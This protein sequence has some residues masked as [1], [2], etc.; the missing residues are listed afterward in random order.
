MYRNGK[1]S[2]IT[3][4]ISCTIANWNSKKSEIR[5]LF[6]CS[7]LNKNI[8]SIIDGLES[9]ELEQLKNGNVPT[10]AQIKNSIANNSGEF[11]AF[12]R[13]ELKMLKL[14]SYTVTNHIDTFR[15]LE[16]YESVQGKI[17]I[18]SL[19]L[20]LLQMFDIFCN[21][22]GL[23]VNS[24]ARHHQ[25]IRSYINKAIAHSLLSESKNPY[26]HYQIKTELTERVAL[27]NYELSKLEDLQF[28]GA[29][30]DKEL[31]VLEMFLLSC[32]T[33]LRYSDVQKITSD[34]II[35]LEGST[36]LKFRA[37]K[38]QK[39]ESLNLSVLFGGSALGIIRSNIR[40]GQIFENISNVY[41]NILLKSISVAAG[42][43]KPLHFH[44]ARHT[45]A[46][47]LITKGLDIL[48]VQKLMQH[49]SLITTSIYAKMT[50][51]SLNKNL[52][53]IFE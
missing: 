46:T 47:L 37:Q 9:Y 43:D 41:V 29:C 11:V 31:Q 1:N 50:D 15:L 49:S 51:Q 16:K 39:V 25:T 23:S 38:T 4:G 34:D 36:Y 21:N 48:S 2:Y 40:K 42:I 26:R 14:S 22:V 32:Y 52:K 5:N 17:M 24:I 30:S 45:F 6:N 3:T 19:N 7:D 28:S 27:T 13:N 20:S 35:E 33:G 44:I 18:S 53:L 12:C 8:R 10:F